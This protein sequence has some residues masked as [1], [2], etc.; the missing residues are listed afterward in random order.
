M[1]ATFTAAAT[2]ALAPSLYFLATNPDA[3]IFGN[4]EFPRLRLLDAENIRIRKTMTPW[5]K[6]R[7]FV[8]EV[9]TPS[10]PVFLAFFSVAIGPIRRRLAVGSIN[11]APLRL[12][13]L[14][15]AFVLLGCFLPSRYQYQHF[16]ALIP[17]LLLGVAYAGSGRGEARRERLLHPI[18]LSVLAI[19]AVLLAVLNPRKID[20]PLIVTGPELLDR[21]EWFSQ[22]AAAVGAEI[23][24]Y[25]PFGRVLTL[26]P[27]WPIA[28]G[29]AIYPEF[30]TGP[31]AWRSA[32]FVE[33][34]QRRRLH[35]VAPADLDAF[36]GL[37]PPAAILTGVEDE[38]L[39][40][41]LIAYAEAHH[42]Q[43]TRLSRKRD[44]WLP[45]SGTLEGELGNK[46]EGN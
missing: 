22:R 9:V 39:E 2:V 20:S 28:G 17:L 32:E 14:V 31:F 3:F 19:L 16:F 15:A 12:L 21:D 10:L 45:L 11:P 43:K 24:R 25:V 5:R 29:V 13:C 46:P 33:R 23:R 8:K 44:L 37:Y 35:L 40:A 7:Y 1:F 6:I 26:A 4:F 34:S 36:L 41:P 42:F 27:A 30:A 18:V 38:D